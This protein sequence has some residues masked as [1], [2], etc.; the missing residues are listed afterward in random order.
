MSNIKTT[1]TD[2]EIPILFED[3]GLLVVDK[4]ANL[5]VQEDQTGDPD[6]LSLCKSYI[7]Q[8]AGGSNFLGLVHRL[9]RPVGGVMVFAKQ[10]NAAADLQ[11]QF[12]ERQVQKTYW[13]VVRG[14][15]PVNGF[16]Q[17]MLVKDRS[18]NRVSVV[19]Q[20]QS[21]A[22]EAILSFQRLAQTDQWSL[23]EIHLQTGR[24]HQ[25]RV[26]FAHEGFPIWGDVKYG[27]ADGRTD[28]LALRSVALE[29]KHPESGTFVSFT[30]YPEQGD[31][32]WNLFDVDRLQ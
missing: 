6:L 5:L 25:I 2:P 10:P 4:P 12:K 16:F 7:Q 3:D 18:N 20:Q 22:K 30:S 14:T 23:V 29:I 24:P 31:A 9:D 15:P 28:A 19:R 11:K 27:A 13:A 17:H 21:D 1:G 8:Q 32:P 26:Q